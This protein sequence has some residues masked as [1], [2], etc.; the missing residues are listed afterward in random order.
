MAQRLTFDFSDGSIEQLRKMT[1]ETNIESYAAL[2]SNALRLYKWWLRLPSE[3][4]ELGVVKNG[5]L[6]KIVEFPF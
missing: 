4:Y 5:E 1:E 3:G 2:I 6:I